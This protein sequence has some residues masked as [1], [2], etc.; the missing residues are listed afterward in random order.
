MDELKEKLADYLI[1]LPDGSSKVP[2]VDIENAIGLK[3]TNLAEE[4]DWWQ[5]FLLMSNSDIEFIRIELR[6]N[7]QY[8]L[9]VNKDSKI[10]NYKKLGKR[11]EVFFQRWELTDQ[12]D[13]YSVLLIRVLNECTYFFD[14]FSSETDYMNLF[15]TLLGK[16]IPKYSDDRSRLIK[17][18]IE[19][20]KDVFELACIL[21]TLFDVLS[22]FE[23]YQ[24]MKELKITLLRVLDIT[25]NPPFFLDTDIVNGEINIYKS[26]AELLD[27][28]LIKD[29]LHWLS[30]YPEVRKLF[31]NAL[32]KYSEYNQTD[33]NARTIY[34]DLRASLEK[35]VKLILGNSKTLENNKNE[36]E[37]WL[38]GKGTHK[39]V[40]KIFSNIL[41]SYIVFMN[42]VKHVSNYNSNDL[43][44][45]VYQTAIMMRMLLEKERKN[46]LIKPRS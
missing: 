44:F 31:A 40:I 36:I 5:K 34:D 25:A 8:S 1:A 6:I 10:P 22:H 24:A 7:D 13:N 15:C 12:K 39:Q 45:M 28:H 29:S 38:K 27:N 41:N 35:L 11:K 42:D 30:K 21:Q 3:L 46:E 4:Y 20:T 19:E 23:N 2:F 18:M 33:E 32:E 43:E 16:T 14:S 17:K 37:E 9:W 26:G